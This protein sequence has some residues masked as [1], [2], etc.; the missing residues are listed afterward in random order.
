MKNFIQNAKTDIETI[1]V[2]SFSLNKNIIIA[3]RK[4]WCHFCAYIGATFTLLRLS[5]T[6][7]DWEF[8]CLSN[9]SAEEVSHVVDVYISSLTHKVW[10][11]Y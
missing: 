8:D 7:W 3:F 11:P 9:K 2:L 5:L 6:K 1:I 10:V 4:K